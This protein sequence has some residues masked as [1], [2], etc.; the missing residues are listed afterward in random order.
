[1]RRAAIALG[2]AAAEVATPQA[3][4]ALEIDGDAGVR[5]LTVRTHAEPGERAEGV[6]LRLARR[7]VA[8][9]GGELRVV[10]A[11]SSLVLTA[12]LPVAAAPTALRA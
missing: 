6:G 3:R 7:I 10:A 9:D 12:E 5:R 8:A 1:M 2:L 4:I 11:D